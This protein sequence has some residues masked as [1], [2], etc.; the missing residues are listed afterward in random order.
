MIFEDVAGRSGC[1]RRYEGFV[2]VVPLENSVSCGDLVFCCG[3]TATPGPLSRC[4]CR[5]SIACWVPV[6]PQAVLVRS[7]QSKDV[8]LL[9]LRHENQVLHRQ[10]DGRPRWDHTDRLWPTALSGL[11]DRHRWTEIFSVTPATILRW[12]RHLLVRKWTYTD[13]HD[14]PPVLRSRRWSFG[15]RG[16]VR[17]GP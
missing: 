6:R 1:R 3:I 5:S 12:H 13:R 16:R 10:L 9:V 11:V 14:H 4:S 17:P 15:W 2:D 8:E 7:E